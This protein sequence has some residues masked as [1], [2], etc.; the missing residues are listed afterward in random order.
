MIRLGRK[1]E[2]LVR[3]KISNLLRKFVTYGHKKFDRIGPRVL[4]F[5]GAYPR[6]E[7]LKGAS[8]E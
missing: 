1:L 4:A 6:V 3:E 2:R 7:H 8:L 5:S